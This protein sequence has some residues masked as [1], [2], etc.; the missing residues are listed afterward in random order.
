VPNGDSNAAMSEDLDLKRLNVKPRLGG[1]GSDQPWNPVMS[2]SQ[3]TDV[4]ENFARSVVRM[5]VV[6]VLRDGSS[7]APSETI[8][9]S[10]GGT[11]LNRHKGCVLI[12]L[13]FHSGQ[14]TPHFLRNSTF[15]NSSHADLSGLKCDEG[16]RPFAPS[17]Q[18][19]AVH[20]AV[21]ARH[22]QAKGCL[23]IR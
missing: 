1:D 11:Y 19:P 2:S 8:C 9:C 14:T 13:S 18:R 15:G 17:P 21:Q 5:A 6:A 4:L 22:W 3:L 12:T 16:P 23:I 10:L 20:K 7:S